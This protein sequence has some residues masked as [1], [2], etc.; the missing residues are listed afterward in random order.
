M[1]RTNTFSGPTDQVTSRPLP[2]HHPAQRLPLIGHDDSL[3]NSPTHFSELLKLQQDRD[4][5]SPNTKALYKNFQEHLD[6]LGQKPQ[7]PK[8]KV[9]D[10][11]QERNPEGQPVRGV[12]ADR[13]NRV[14]SNLAVKSERG[15]LATTRQGHGQGQEK[16][17]LDHLAERPSRPYQ[18][19][20]PIYASLH[21]PDSSKGD[22]DPFSAVT[23]RDSSGEP[24]LLSAINTK[25]NFPS[26]TSTS[27]ETV[28]ASVHTA[29][30]RTHSTPAGSA[31]M[32]QTPGFPGTGGSGPQ[33]TGTGIGDQRPKMDM[34]P[35]L[36]TDS[37][38]QRHSARYYQQQR[39]ASGSRIRTVSENQAR[40][41]LSNQQMR[42]G[43]STQVRSGSYAHQGRIVGIGQ[44]PIST[45]PGSGVHGRTGSEPHSGRP[46]IAG[47]PFRSGQPK[48]SQPNPHP[49]QPTPGQ[50]TATFGK[51]YYILD[52]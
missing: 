38:V 20:S 8:Y 23:T 30:S 41:W 4:T 27:T 36:Q 9:L 28:P 52:V 11:M 39:P 24:D 22:T 25:V 3:P 44:H 29:V 50:V 6:Q 12:R 17:K 40:P 7:K 49:S 16:M 1:K 47:Q 21:D 46:P 43:S 31:G 37:H 26:L 10:W 19:Q 51:D 2:L 33:R 34:R 5:P 45:R 18:K 32:R 15:Q 35:R 14:Q 42:P 13:D 48:P